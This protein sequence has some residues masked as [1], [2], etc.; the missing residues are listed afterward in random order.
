MQRK[1][2]HARAPSLLH[3]A[4][5]S[6]GLSDTRI[7][8]APRCLVQVRERI[9]RKKL[10][11]TAR[12]H[13]SPESVRDGETRWMD[14]PPN[15]H[16]SPDKLLHGAAF[17]RAVPTRINRQPH[18]TKEGGVESLGEPTG[19]RTKIRAAGKNKKTTVINR[20][21][22]RVRA[23]NARKLTSTLHAN[24]SRAEH[25]PLRPWITSFPTSPSFTST[26]KFMSLSSVF[27]SLKSVS[28][29]CDSLKMSPTSDTF[30]CFLSTDSKTS[31]STACNPVDMTSSNMMPSRATWKQ[32]R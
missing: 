14:T 16:A 9:S 6:A 1:G 10:C 17:R 20:I 32:R 8:Y 7:Q 5:W 26:G 24:A 25:S 30:N 22:I 15:P 2:T 23:A 3:Q 11:G 4:Q 21:P 28:S 29:R 12:Q 18:K 19:R 31:A 27:L 13:R